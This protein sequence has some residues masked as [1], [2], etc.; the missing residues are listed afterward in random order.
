MTY[1]VIIQPEAEAELDAAYRWIYEQAPH[2]A[3]QWFAGIVEAIL[4]LEQFPQRCP[5]APENAHFT[6][7]IRQLLYG[8]RRYAYR[9]LF[10]VQ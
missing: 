2:A 9:I 4:S 1:R 10:T 3:S 7:E 8:R 5:L 6:A